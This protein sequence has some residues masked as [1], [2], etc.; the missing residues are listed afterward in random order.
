[1]PKIVD[2]DQRRREIVEV[3]WKF[4]AR[5]GIEK[6]N[7]RDLAAAAGY[8]NGA[9]KPYF[10]TRDALL[11]ATFNFVADATNRRIKQNA[12][13]MQGLEAIA[14]FAREVLP[15]DE[16]R[17]NE[18][19]IAVHFWHLALGDPKLAVVNAS[20]MDQ[21]RTMLDG[22]LEQI[23]PAADAR[24]LMARDS[25][26]NFLLGAQASSVLDAEVN[27]AV[28]L[29]EQLKYQLDLLDSFAR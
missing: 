8:A 21:W 25:L 27:T 16:L 7:L 18:A 12:A 4:I 22:W 28:L 2:H 1:M 11:V 20:T 5:E 6:L 17:R 13:G 14:A 29:E 3:T 9:L 26:I 15:L 19:R 10:P 23:F 24:T